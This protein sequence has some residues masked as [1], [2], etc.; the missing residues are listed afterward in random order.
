MALTRYGYFLCG[1]G[2]S[3]ARVFGL[4]I[5]I[6]RLEDVNPQTIKN[7]IDILCKYCGH[8]T[9]ASKHVPDRQE[10][11]TTWRSAIETYKQRLLSE[12]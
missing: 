8:S 5:G 7:Q 6:K 1:A 4:D 9:V 2:A 3:I 11:S 10:M 12:Y